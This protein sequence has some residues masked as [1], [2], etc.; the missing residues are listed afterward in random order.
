MKT[1]K[2]GK[3]MFRKCRQKTSTPPKKREF[4]PQPTRAERKKEGERKKKKKKKKGKKKKEKKKK[5]KEKK[6][7]LKKGTKQK[8][9][10]YLPLVESVFCDRTKKRH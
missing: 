3:T 2:N 7:T 9:H 4:K 8:N 6:K 5:K 10:N 1:G